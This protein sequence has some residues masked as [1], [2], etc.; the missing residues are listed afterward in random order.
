M[1]TQSFSLA[2]NVT[3]GFGIF[4]CPFCTCHPLFATKPKRPLI[5]GGIAIGRSKSETANPNHGTTT[6]RVCYAN[7]RLNIFVFSDLPSR[8]T[9]RHAP[10]IK[11]WCEHNQYYQQSIE[12]TYGLLVRSEEKGRGVLEI[13]VY[14]AC[15][16]SVFFSICQLVQTPVTV[17]AAGSKPCVACH[18]TM[19]ALRAGS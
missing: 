17:P 6:P 11:R 10:C 7:Q 15:M 8:H 13:A 9:W 4:L 19:S 3:L 5:R 16:L 18:T 12:S 14:A 2:I 1:A